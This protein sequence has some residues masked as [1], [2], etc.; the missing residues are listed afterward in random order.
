M[1]WK[2]VTEVARKGVYTAQYDKGMGLHDVLRKVAPKM[3][4]RADANWAYGVADN[5]N[6]KKYNSPKY[7]ANPLET[8]LPNAPDMEVFC[9]YGVGIPTERAYIYK[10]SPFNDTCLIPFRIDGSQHANREEA[11]GCLKDGTYFV[12]GDETVPVLSAGLPC[13]K[14]WRGR[15]KFNPSGAKSYVREFLHTPPQ[16][17]LEGRGVQSG[18]HVD[19]MG[20]FALIETILRLASGASG[21]DIGGDNVHTDVFQWAKKVRV[22]V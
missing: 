6:D 13:A 11:G 4:A 18:S 14:I 15:T 16:S 3:M 2:D 22:K 1:S 9:L 17:L 20:N 5:P 12:D 21:E 19:I 7:W 10:L 8:T